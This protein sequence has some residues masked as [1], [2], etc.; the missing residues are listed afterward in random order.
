VR[1]SARGCDLGAGAAAAVAPGGDDADA[2]T[3]RAPSASPARRA[4]PPE[5]GSATRPGGRGAPA[6]TRPRPTRP[7]RPHRPAARA[8]D[9]PDLVS[10]R[11][12]MPA[13][14]R[15]QAAYVRYKTQPEAYVCSSG[16]ELAT[17]RKFA[18]KLAQEESAFT[19]D[20]L[21]YNGLAPCRVSLRI[22]DAPA[23]YA[24][25]VKQDR[26]ARR[27]G[28][29][30]A[31]GARRRRAALAGAGQGV[32]R[33][34]LE[35]SGGAFWRRGRWAQARGHGAEQPGPAEQLPAA[36]ARSPRTGAPC[37]LRLAGCMP[38]GRSI[39][40]TVGG[41]VW[42]DGA[43]A[44]VSGLPS[45]STNACVS[46]HTHGA[47]TDARTHAAARSSTRTRTHTTC[48]NAIQ[49]SSAPTLPPSH[50]PGA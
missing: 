26:R 33:A 13:V 43:Q 28:G 29:A 25:P 48:T 16:W 17:S 20:T 50:P 31:R 36:R 18:E 40:F 19:E 22:V 11:D 49:K 39:S 2:Q 38:R 32:G 23:E 27:G 14:E 15:W 44:A 46:A 10:R 37:C 30:A 3:A 4:R 8:P 35:G 1:G 9:L 47:C 21:L 5:R 12:S 34:G 6:P 24:V 41:A 7:T 42:A 45:H